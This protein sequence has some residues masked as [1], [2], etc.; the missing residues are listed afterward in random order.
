MI[1]NTTNLNVCQDD[2][3]RSIDASSN[4]LSNLLKIANI[5]NKP[6]GSVQVSC[7]PSPLEYI[8]NVVWKSLIIH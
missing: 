6:K 3:P 8:F 5:I 4:D 1:G 2:A 7:A